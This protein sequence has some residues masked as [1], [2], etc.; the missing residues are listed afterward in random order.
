MLVIDLAKEVSTNPQTL[1][2][3]LLEH[4]QLSRFFNAS[5][6]VERQSDEGEIAGGKGCRRQVT[7]M[8]QTFSEEILKADLSGITYRIV[9]SKPIKHH[10]GRIVFE[11]TGD[12]T[13]ISYHI[14]G[15]AP[16]HLPT[17]LVKFLIQRDIKSALKKLAFHFEKNKAPVLTT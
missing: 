4:E 2:E 3:T 16:N 11:T 7:T 6:T 12:T 1:L 14:K 8:G 10:L 5:F 13:L 15:I 9:G 17:F